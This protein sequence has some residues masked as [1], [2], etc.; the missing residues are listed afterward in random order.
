MPLVVFPCIATFGMPTF[1][2]SFAYRIGTTGVLAT[3]PVDIECN[4]KQFPKLIQQES[5]LHLPL[6]NKRLWLPN[7]HHG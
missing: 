5:N 7:Y 3:S 1:C 4:S 6:R 2:R